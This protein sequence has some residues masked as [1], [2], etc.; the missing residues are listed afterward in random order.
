MLVI[1]VISKDNFCQNELGNQSERHFFD[2]YSCIINN[3]QLVNLLLPHCRKPCIKATTF[4][5]APAEEGTPVRVAP[6]AKQRKLLHNVFLDDQEFPDQSNDYDH[7]L[8]NID[9]GPILRKLKHPVPDLN[10][11]VDPIFYSEFKYE[12]HKAQ[13]RPDVDFS[14]LDPNLQ[15]KV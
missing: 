13:M 4:C 11:P 12:K 15:E 1:R 8:H 14:H 7:V 6:K 10:V 3:F 9:G 2:N 5:M